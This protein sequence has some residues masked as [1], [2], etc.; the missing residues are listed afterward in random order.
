L[1]TRQGNKNESYNFATV[2]ANTGNMIVNNQPLTSKMDQN[3]VIANIQAMTKASTQ[4]RISNKS[5][6]LSDSKHAYVHSSGNPQLGNKSLQP[7]GHVN[8]YN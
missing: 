4:N 2:T 1:N 6:C 5:K 3:V 8:K 7:T